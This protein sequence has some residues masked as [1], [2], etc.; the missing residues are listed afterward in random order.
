MF[1]GFGTKALCVPL[2]VYAVDSDAAV[3]KLLHLYNLL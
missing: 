3:R 1:S 2:L